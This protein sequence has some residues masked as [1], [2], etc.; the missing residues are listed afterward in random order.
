MEVWNLDGNWSFI[1]TTLIQPGSSS[2]YQAETDFSQDF[3][4]DGS[5]GAP[6][7]DY[8]VI[9]E[10]GNTALLVDDDN[11]LYAENIEWGEITSVS[12][13]GGSVP[14]SNSSAQPAVGAE[15]VNGVNK[16]I[17]SSAVTGN[18]LE[19]S[20][21]QDWSY[22]SLNI[23]SKDSADYYQAEVDFNQDFNGDGSIGAPEVDYTVIEEIGNTVLL[24]D[25]D[26]YLYAE[27]IELGE[28]TSVSN[29][30]GSVP[31]SNSSAQPAVG[32][33]VVNGVNKIIQSS[34]VTGNLLESSFDQDWSYSSLNIHSK[35]S[36]DYYQAEVDFNQDFN[37]DGSIGAPEVDYTVIEEIGN[38]A[39]LVDDDN[40]LYAENIEWGEI[41]SVSNYG[42]SVPMS[43][44]SAQPAVG[45]EVVNGVNKIIQSSAVTGNLLE[46]SFDQDWSY[47][48]LNIH[49]KDSADYYQAE[50]DFNQDFNGDGTIGDSG[51]TGDFWTTEPGWND[52]WG[53]ENRGDFNFYDWG[54][55]YPATAGADINA[56]AAFESWGGVNNGI[57]DLYGGENIVAVLDTGI[58]Y[59]H[60]DLRDNILINPDEI[61]NNG[62][63]DDSNGY[64]DDYY[65]YDFAYNDGNPYD[66]HGHGTHVAGTIGAAS[67]GK[68]V[69]GSNPAAKLVGV[70][71]MDDNGNG[72]T[73]G[74]IS[75]IDY[76][77]SRGAKILNMSLGGT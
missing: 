18:L 26:N 39:L 69:I 25:D 77:I 70:K 65:G 46:S 33:E 72:Y 10:I 66:F 51:P 55:Y 63:D 16:I 50:V 27:N 71:V 35:D 76:S 59:T 23:H 11:Y 38:T 67:N 5:I 2:Y 42:G 15:V 62:V 54:N 30:G 47:S 40:Y 7:V 22:S 57:S 32:A 52:L 53:F 14:M 17:Q 73:A 49:S 28:I 8:T 4:G 6:E 61:P 58:R 37:G 64:T 21:D 56:V 60:E 31:M 19:S 44:S 9:E 24:V 43:N 68:G 45:A 41:T 3:D 75:G 12:N 48:S 13:Y 36:A 20:F 29:Y 34:A 1:S 74:I